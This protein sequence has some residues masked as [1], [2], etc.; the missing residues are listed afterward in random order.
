MWGDRLLHSPFPGGIAGLDIGL[1]FG[2]GLGLGDE[3]SLQLRHGCG[4]PHFVWL[5][6]SHGSNRAIAG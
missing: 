2:I 4:E 5:D 3:Q 6:G 1:G